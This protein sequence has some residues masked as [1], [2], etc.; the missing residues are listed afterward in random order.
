MPAQQ[1]EQYLCQ[2]LLEDVEAE[3][4]AAVEAEG[5]VVAAVVEVEVV[6]AEDF[7]DWHGLVGCQEGEKNPRP[8][9]T[10]ERS[11]DHDSSAKNG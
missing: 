11:S 6:A 2:H 5:D 10:R 3:A 4:E 9:E 7:G 1:E 8:Y